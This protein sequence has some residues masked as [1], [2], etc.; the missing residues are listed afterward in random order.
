MGFIS[1]A[2]ILFFLVITVGILVTIVLVGITIYRIIRSGRS[3]EDKKKLKMIGWIWL[4]I[5][6]YLVYA[7][8]RI[9]IKV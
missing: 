5:I 2:L 4:G 9:R 1:A 7:Y 8:I 6:A 3:Q